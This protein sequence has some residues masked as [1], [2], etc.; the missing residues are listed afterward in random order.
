MRL[1]TRKYV[2]VKASLQRIPQV[3]RVKEAIGAC[4]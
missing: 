1:M 3:M 2:R 4:R